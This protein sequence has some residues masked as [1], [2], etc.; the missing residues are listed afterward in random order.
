MNFKSLNYFII[1]L[2]VIG[3]L[4]LFLYTF[5]YNPKE[6]SLLEDNT[7]Y[8]DKVISV[9]GTIKNYNLR[10]NNLF[11]EVCNYSK[12]MPVVYF[13]VSKNNSQ[14]IKD[15]YLLKKEIKVSGKYTLYNQKQEVILYK[16]EV[17]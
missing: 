10:E 6:I 3:L 9:S 1:V 7:K 5:F 17:K 8:L 15:I 12:C 11:F 13:N 4:S 14:I 16:Y 2:T